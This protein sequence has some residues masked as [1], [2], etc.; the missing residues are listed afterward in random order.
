MGPARSLG[1]GASP[2]LLPAT[3][4]H[5]WCTALMHPLHMAW[6]QGSVPTCI[7]CCS[8]IFS[9]CWTRNVPCSA[10]ESLTNSRPPFAVP[11]VLLGMYGSNATVNG[12][13]GNMLYRTYDGCCTS[14]SASTKWQDGCV[15]A[16]PG[17]R[18]FSWGEEFCVQ[19]TVTRFTVSQSCAGC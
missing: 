12:S 6:H 19:P 7:P 10:R 5:A 8:T 18:L 14:S 2:L 3:H 16:N 4:Q 9:S 17:T 15:H 1:Q 13:T 11:E